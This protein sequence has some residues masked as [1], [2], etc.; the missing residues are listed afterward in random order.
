ML[1]T[2]A[3]ILSPLI[4]V[5]CCRLC[6]VPPGRMR[7]NNN[8]S[9]LAIKVHWEPGG[10][11]NQT[12]YW[13]ECLRPLPAVRSAESPRKPCNPAI[14]PMASIINHA[15]NRKSLWRSA[16]KLSVSGACKGNSMEESMKVTLCR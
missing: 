15:S 14:P 11:S 12:A 4:S 7:N 3:L 5:I 2:L 16:Q 9:W 13:G 8:G 10:V 6:K 1:F